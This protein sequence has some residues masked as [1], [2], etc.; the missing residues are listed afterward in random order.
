[1]TRNLTLHK[2]NSLLTHS[3]QGLSSAAR[4]TFTCILHI[5]EILILIMIM[6]M[7]IMIIIIIKQSI[8]SWRSNLNFIRPTTRQFISKDV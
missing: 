1:M 4:I 8:S 6:I 3:Q 5:Y 7:I 2:L